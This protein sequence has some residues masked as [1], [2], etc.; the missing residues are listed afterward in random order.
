M[1]AGELSVVRVC[2]ARQ[3]LV[4]GLR[5]CQ[6]VFH[7][8]GAVGG[9]E[10]G[11]RFIFLTMM[12]WLGTLVGWSAEWVPLF[13]GKNLEGWTPKIKGQPVGGNLHNTFRV[14]D[15]LLKVGYKGY[16]EFDEQFGHIFYKDKFS[17]YRIRLEYRFVGEQLKG[18][19]AWA[20]RNSG[21]MLHCQHPE[22]MGLNQDFPVSIEVQLLGGKENGKRTT[23]NLCTPGTN[24][25]MDG[26]LQ[27]RHCF[28][29]ESKTYRGEQW[30]TVEVLVKGADVIEHFVN[31]ERVMRYHKPQYDPKDD[32]AKKLIK[33]GQLLLRA[34][35]ISLQSESHP[36]E[37]RKVEVKVLGK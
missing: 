8:R 23:A 7:L 34:G 21:V 9:V 14:E 11:M 12:V 25:V 2:D 36:V 35:Y 22:S 28:S 32:D 4:A 30:V 29:S 1:S 18:G 5:G 13:N 27:T 15:C 20:W 37:F 33:G 26:K 24:V 19:P 31:G 3:S 10:K 16:G 17:H 6:N